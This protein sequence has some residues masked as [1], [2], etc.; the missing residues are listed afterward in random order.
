MR[1]IMKTKG[2]LCTTAASLLLAV[3]LSADQPYN[4]D[5]LPEDCALAA[6]PRALQTFHWLDCA[7]EPR[8]VWASSE[9]PRDREVLTSPRALEHMPRLAHATRIAREPQ[10][11]I[12]LASNG[13]P[14]GGYQSLEGRPQFSALS[15]V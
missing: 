15:R 7:P 11:R 9:R 6:A 8:S 13:R 1:N 5:Q 3:A 12:V 4:L 2:I 14:V 10:R